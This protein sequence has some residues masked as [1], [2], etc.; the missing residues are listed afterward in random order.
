MMKKNI[1]FVLIAALGMVAAEG[2]RPGYVLAQE[3]GKPVEGKAAGKAPA[4]AAGAPAA[5]STQPAKQAKPARAAK[6][7]AKVEAVEPAKPVELTT[8]APSDMVKGDVNFTVKLILPEGEKMGRDVYFKVAGYTVLNS[9]P[10]LY[11]WSQFG[12]EETTKKLERANVLVFTAGRNGRDGKGRKEALVSKPFIWQAKLP[13]DAKP[14]QT[15]I[16]PTDL[17]V[18]LE[19]KRQEEAPEGGLTG[20]EVNWDLRLVGTQFTVGAMWFDKEG[21]V[22]TEMFANLKE[23]QAG[24][25]AKGV[26]SAM[27]LRANETDDDENPIIRLKVVSGGQRRTMGLSYLA[28]W[29]TGPGDGMLLMERTSHPTDDFVRMIESPEAAQ[30]RKHIVF[31]QND[32]GD[33]SNANKANLKGPV[34]YG[35]L[36]G[37]Y[38]KFQIDELVLNNDPTKDPFKL[39]GRVVV[40]PDGSRNLVGE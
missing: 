34:L 19:L 31:K 38:F 13:G 29:M 8:E 22:Q 30:F 25:S 11:E 40:Q 20:T 39:T 1:C 10:K 37:K 3:G 21:K 14:G 7:P 35:K 33:F 4:K 23:L 5:P 26:A 28:M 36:A 16:E 18:T 15:D 32:L 17:T 9:R 2:G 24:L 6:A 12:K 27:I